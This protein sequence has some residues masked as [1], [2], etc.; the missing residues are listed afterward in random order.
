MHLIGTVL[1]G[2]MVGLI[3]RFLRPGPDP[4]GFIVTSVIGIIGSLVATYLGQALGMYAP[5][6]P[7]GFVGAI[8]GAI[9]VLMVYARLQHSNAV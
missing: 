5:G 8:V 6:Q 7:A 2:F 9:L 4:S 1:I 3:A